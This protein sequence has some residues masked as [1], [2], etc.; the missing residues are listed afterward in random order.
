MVPRLA[1]A[2]GTY[3][4]LQI[5]AFYLTHISMHTC[6]HDS[7]HVHMHTHFANFIKGIL[8]KGILRLL[9]SKVHVAPFCFPFLHSHTEFFFTGIWFK[10]AILC[11]LTTFLMVFFFFFSFN[12]HT[13]DDIYLSLVFKPVTFNNCCWFWKC[14][15]QK[16]MCGSSSSHTQKGSMFFGPHHQTYLWKIGIS[17]LQT[18]KKFPWHRVQSTPLRFRGRSF[19]LTVIDRQV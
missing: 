6:L 9:Q 8:S 2:Q 13:L 3:K 11:D 14:A 18:E 15:K 10:D 17:W 4:G 1:R 19:S 7:M 16:K 12:K 5:W